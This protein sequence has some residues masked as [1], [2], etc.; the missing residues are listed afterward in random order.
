[1]KYFSVVY[2]AIFAPYAVSSGDFG[3]V[4]FGLTASVLAVREAEPAVAGSAL[5]RSSVC[6][7]T[8]IVANNTKTKPASSLRSIG[9]MMF[10]FVR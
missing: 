10:S 8:E 6:A 2:S 1:M 3:V 4:Y 7:S 5:L 9:D